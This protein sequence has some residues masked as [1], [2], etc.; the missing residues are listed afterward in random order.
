MHVPEY[1][2]MLTALIIFINQIIKWFY[3]QSSMVLGMLLIWWCQ[4]EF[5]YFQQF[6]VYKG[7]D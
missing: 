2:F 5:K 4:Q 1:K 3:S 6:S 7:V